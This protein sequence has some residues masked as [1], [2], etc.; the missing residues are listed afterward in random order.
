MPGLFAAMLLVTGC[1]RYPCQSEL[2]PYPEQSAQPG[3]GKVLV[4]T[5]P[6]LLCQTNSRS[7]NLRTFALC[8]RSKRQFNGLPAIELPA[9]TQLDLVG[10]STVDRGKGGA[11]RFLYF[12]IQDV[13]AHDDKLLRVPTFMNSYPA[14]IELT[15]EYP[16]QWNREQYQI[17]RNS[18]WVRIADIDLDCCVRVPEK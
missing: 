13:P 10:E 17:L 16:S 12:I 18:P 4:R 9:G 6:T 7:E 15:N 14:E 1:T 3:I 5:G 2:A 11:Y 8:G